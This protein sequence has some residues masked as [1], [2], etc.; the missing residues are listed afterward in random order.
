[1]KIHNW[2]E[3]NNKHKEDNKGF[4]YESICTTNFI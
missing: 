3:N 1:M 4:N 2:Q